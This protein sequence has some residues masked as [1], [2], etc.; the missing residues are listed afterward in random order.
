MILICRD[1]IP[2]GGFDWS[3]IVAF[4]G[5]ILVEWGEVAIQEMGRGYGL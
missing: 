4:A 2:C 5:G 3:E 1:E